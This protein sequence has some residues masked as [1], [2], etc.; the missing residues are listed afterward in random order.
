MLILSV[1]EYR[2]RYSDVTGVVSHPSQR[3]R[4][5]GA[6]TAG[7]T[8]A[9]TRGNRLGHP[10]VVTVKPCSELVPQV[11]VIHI[12]MKLNLGN[13]DQAAEQSWAA[14]RRGLLEIGITSFHVL[15]Q[16]VRGPL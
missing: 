7:N 9:L 3:T 14:V 4:K 11:L 5:M 15:S 2:C 13:L 1:Q 12:V 10:T 8:D 16:Q 6:D